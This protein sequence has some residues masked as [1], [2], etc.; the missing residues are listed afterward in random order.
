MSSDAWMD[1][2]SDDG[3][4]HGMVLMVHNDGGVLH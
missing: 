4:M 2:D 3:K 1:Y